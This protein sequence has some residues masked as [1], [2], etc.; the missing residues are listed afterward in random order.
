MIINLILAIVLTVIA[1]SLLAT[2]GQITSVGADLIKGV[3]RATRHSKILLGYMG[4]AYQRYRKN[5]HR[6]LILNS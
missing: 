2:F 5:I 4:R 1:I 6:D 3:A